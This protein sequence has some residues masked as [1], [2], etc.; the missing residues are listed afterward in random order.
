MR[1]RLA[2]TCSVADIASS[3]GI[4]GIIRRQLDRLFLQQ[5]EQ[6][7]QV[8]WQ[9]M[10]LQHLRWRLLDSSSSLAALA[11]EIGAQ[12]ASCAG[13]L[14]RRRFGMSLGEFRKEAEGQRAEAAKVSPPSHGS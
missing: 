11:D 2:S 9:E 4:A 6:T 14:F 12:D 1:Q 3:A 10:R 8:Y 5:F 7:A 13:K